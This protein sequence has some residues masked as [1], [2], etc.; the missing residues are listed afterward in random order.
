MEYGTFVETL[1]QILMKASEISE[2][3]IHFEEKGGRFSQNGDRLLIE[4]AQHEEST[5]ICAIYTKEIYG[6]YLDGTSIEDL[7]QEILQD[8]DSVK[9][10]QMYKRTMLMTDYGKVRGKLYIRLV[11]EERNQQLLEDAVYKVIG[12]IALV[13]YMKVAE[14]EK[15]ITSTKIPGALVKLWGKDPDHVFKEAL[16]NTYFISPPRIYR[17]ESMVF[18]P[19]YEGENFMDLTSNLVLRR[20]IIGNCLSTTTKINGAVAVFL[21]GVAERLYSLLESD[22]YITFTSVHEAMIHDVRSVCV[23]D[24]RQ[25]LEQTLAEATPKE[26]FLSAQVYRYTHDSRRFSCLTLM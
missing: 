20:A 15:C 3:D 10:S 7:A 17:W 26:E 23:G 22:F 19:D 6:L 25:I 24:L 1:K 12:D 16:L 4:F 21:P 5:E 2:E 9:D 11:N 8:I 14:D 13:V 18:N